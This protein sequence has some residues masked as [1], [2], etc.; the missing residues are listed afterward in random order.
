MSQGG[1]GDGERHGRCE[2][3]RGSGP[4][5]WGESRTTSNKACLV[6]KKN[7][8]WTLSS[9]VP[10]FLHIACSRWI[11]FLHFLK[12]KKM[13]CLWRDREGEQYQ[14][15]ISKSTQMLPGRQEHSYNIIEG[16]QHICASVTHD[17]DRH[18]PAGSHSATHSFHMPPSL[19][20]N[21]LRE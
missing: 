16:V 7:L 21:M 18:C 17:L 3:P 20:R 15:E 13:L 12:F 9:D 1:G 14:P 19:N 6:L 4:C 10:H 2:L 5:C 11:Q 8:S